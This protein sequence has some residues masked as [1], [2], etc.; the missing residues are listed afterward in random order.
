L[1]DINKKIY[2][3]IFW[4]SFEMIVNTSFSLIIQ[5]VLAK[6]LS[7]NDFG[8]LAM[9][10]VFTAFVEVISDVGMSAVLIQKKEEY[11]KS[12]HY[13][14]AN[15][16]GF[17]WSITLFIL[18]TL[19]VAPFAS[20]YMKAEILT[21][22]IPVLCMSLIFNSI[23]L[24]PKSI[25]IK[26]MRF[27]ELAIINNLSNF[28]SGIISIL[29]AILGYGLWSL[30]FYIVLKSLFSIPFYYYYSKWRP[31]IIWKKNCFTEIFSFGITT[32][33]TSF[34]NVLTGK[35]DYFLIG[36]LLGS[37]LLGHYSFAILITNLF[38]D[39]LVAVLNKVLYPVYTNLQ[40]DKNKMLNAFIM[41]TSINITFIY[42]VMFGIILFSEHFLYLFFENKWD[43]S[44]ILIK[45]FSYTVLIQM[46]NNSHTTL[47]RASGEVKS[48]LYLQLIKSLIFFIPLIAYGTFNF[49]LVGSA[50]GYL[51]ATILSI[52]AS[53]V[54]M[55]KIFNFRFM[56]L[57]KVVGKKILYFTLI[58]LI[59]LFLKQHF[60]W[61]ILLVLYTFL[62]LNYFFFYEKEIFKIF[63]RI[64]S[65]N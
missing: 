18:M 62:I 31:K 22:V 19:L 12:E 28:F 37:N 53:F 14:T 59:I 56:V 29:L 15:I 35:F 44:I 13:H 38:R 48:E 20:V 27:K 63:K 32:S 47:I 55:N 25:L 54:V 26:N 52:V 46:L 41:T 33:A 10:V 57:L 3:G 1:I 16:T 23:I 21:K 5:F 34:T 50:I 6:L 40:D 24:I 45:I 17:L 39:R 58:F 61:L 65:S 51:L 64:T 42:P 11:L 8:V 49:G 4:A 60:D 43:D 36:K 7:P 2:K 9:A 30:V